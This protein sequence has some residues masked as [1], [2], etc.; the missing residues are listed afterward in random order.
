MSVV[1]IEHATFETPKTAIL[2]IQALVLYSTNNN[3]SPKDDVFL[4]SH[5]VINNNS[6]FSLGAGHILSSKQQIQVANL[7]TRKKHKANIEMLPENVL[8]HDDDYLMWYE[9]AAIRPMYFNIANTNRKEI[10]TVPWCNLIFL[11]T[12]R[13]ELF[14][15]AYKGNNRPNAGTP[16]FHAPL[17]NIYKQSHLCYGSATRP[18]S[19]N[20]NSRKR[21]CDAVFNTNFSHTNHDKTLNST[22][23]YADEEGVSNGNHFI[24]WKTLH[25]DKKTSF[26]DEVLNPLSKKLNTW[27]KSHV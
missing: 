17:M 21:W 19:L 10:F 25:T 18:R 26:P 22:S 11:A 13:R 14:I 24:F 20:F 12:A 16:L 2:P 5:A 7:L 27:F 6:E 9:K 4:T 15:A 8:A 1:Q 3:N 23:K